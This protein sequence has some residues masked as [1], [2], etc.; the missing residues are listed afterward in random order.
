[1][2]RVLIPIL[3]GII[4]FSFLPL[5]GFSAEKSTFLNLSLNSIEASVCPGESV[6]TLLTVRADPSNT[7]NCNI[8]LTPSDEWIILEITNFT[9][10]PGASRQVKVTLIAGEKTPGTYQGS[11]TMTSNCKPEH[12][13][14]PVILHILEPT[15]SVSPQTIDLELKPYDEKMVNIYI[16][17]GKCSVNLTIS[18]TA[19]L[20][21]G[22]LF[23]IT[24]Q[25]SLS[26]SPYQR[27]ILPVRVKTNGLMKN[28]MIQMFFDSP[29]TEH[30]ET[31]GTQTVKINLSIQVPITVEGEI[32]EI[33]EDEGYMI[34]ETPDGKRYKII[35]REEDKGKYKEGEYIEVEG[36]YNGEVIYPEKIT[37]RATEIPPFELAAPSEIRLKPGESVSVPIEIKPPEDASEY[38]VSEL[39]KAKI[40]I[41]EPLIDIS[42]KI[43]GTGL[44]RKIEITTREGAKPGCDILFLKTTV[45]DRVKVDL[46]PVILRR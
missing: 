16:Q 23:G 2:K 11:I 44:K 18:S 13:E 5:A 6:Q 36:Y 10:S 46:L 42:I 30:S 17:N 15:F 20:I 21:E 4:A 22:S 1:M 37:P 29:Y 32:V 27:V 24:Y 3:V 28:S 8:T 25:K 19:D 39:E 43:T 14:I 34:I 26:L 35:L 45:G 31:F 41:S 33:N 38:V 9:L 7:E 12:V 40:E